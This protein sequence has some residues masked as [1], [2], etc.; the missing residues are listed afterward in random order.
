[1]KKTVKSKIKTLVLVGST[2]LMSNAAMSQ[3]VP[4]DFLTANCNSTAGYTGK[5]ILWNTSPFSNGFGHKIYNDDYNGKTYLKFA[6]RHNALTW[7]DMMTL[8][9]EGRVGIGT[10]APGVKLELFDASTNLTLLKLRNNNWACNQTTAIEFWNGSNKAF[11]TSKIVSQMDGCGSDGEALIFET[12][13]AGATVTTPKLTIKNNGTILIP[14]QTRIGLQK[15][16]TGTTHADAMLS[17]DG[18]IISKSMYVTQ[19]NW[20]DFV[21]DK[22]YALP[23]LYEVE[24]YYKANKHLPLIPSEQDVK[25]N[26]IDVGEMNKLLLQK[27]EEITILMVQQQREIDALKAKIK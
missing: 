14:G 24:A 1:M 23:K 25:E 12:Q 2:L 16:V 10:D 18:K 17:V 3:T 20:A 9:S 22:D 7:T 27:I 19:Q 8:T 26:G 6:A 15:P 13:T 21:F 5:S 4:F 11:A